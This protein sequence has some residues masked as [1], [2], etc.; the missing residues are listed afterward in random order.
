[1]SGLVDL[2]NRALGV[3]DWLVCPAF[4]V[5]SGRPVSAGGQGVAGSDGL[6]P[7]VLRHSAS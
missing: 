7:M 4:P 5:R 1:M 2:D 3:R 6:Y